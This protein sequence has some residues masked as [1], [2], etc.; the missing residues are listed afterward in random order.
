MV[1]AGPRPVRVPLAWG[2]T[3]TLWT[4]L[5]EEINTGGRAVKLDMRLCGGTSGDRIFNSDNGYFD[6]D[7]NI[8]GD[9]KTGKA[10]IA[11]LVLPDTATELKDEPGS[12]PGAFDGFD[13]LASVTG[14]GIEFIGA[15]AFRDRGSLKSVSFPNVEGF[16][17]YA[18]QNCD[19]LI[20]VDCPNLRDIPEDAFRDC[21]SLEEVNFP[22]VRSIS[23]N[24]FNGCT[25]LKEAEF[26]GITGH[27]GG[28][29]AFYGCSSLKSVS[30]PNA[31]GT[32]LY[33]AFRNCIALETVNIPLIAYID[34]QVF[35]NC[36]NLQSITMRATPPYLNGSNQFTGSTPDDFTIRVP[37]G[38]TSAYSS[39]IS[40]NA[41]KF[42]SS[43]GSIIIV[44]Y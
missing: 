30:F 2:V 19:E 41:A 42:N 12:P 17:R 35:Q 22:L 6:P 13:T 24:A 3:E 14:E 8:T 21:T 15:R 32:I 28:N 9:A 37:N 27:I 25:A 39:W 31:S 34:E 38:A 5:L 43:G 40:T 11:T 44:E 16:S 29:N 18:F 36:D 10:L 7:R 33:R 26:P 20:S 4:Q 23:N 1:P